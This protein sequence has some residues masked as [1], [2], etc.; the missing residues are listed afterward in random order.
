MTDDKSQWL[1]TRDVQQALAGRRDNDIKVEINGTLVPLTKI[2][3]ESAG[4]CWVLEPYNGDDLKGA[5][6]VGED[7]APD[8]YPG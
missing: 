5:L 1:T 6:L 2:Y 7:E 3:Y 8:V 4:D